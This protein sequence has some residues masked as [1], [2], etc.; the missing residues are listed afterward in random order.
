[1]PKLAEKGAFRALARAKLRALLVLELSTIEESANARLGSLSSL[2]V[3]LNWSLCNSTCWPA[4]T[5][6]ERP[7]GS[8]WLGIESVVACLSFSL[9]PAVVGVTARALRTLRSV[10]FFLQEPAEEAGSSLALNTAPAN[11]LEPL[12][13]GLSADSSATLAPLPPITAELCALL[14]GSIG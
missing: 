11:S 13:A 10:R 14:A 2:L 9:F 1:M 4:P 3:C 7:C 6:A 8:P 5:L 12:E